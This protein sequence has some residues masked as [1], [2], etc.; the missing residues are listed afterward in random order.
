M[1]NLNEMWTRLAQHQS[2]ADAGGYGDVWRTMCQERTPDVAT[3]AGATLKAAAL[4][5]AWAGASAQKA[6]LR[7]AADAAMMAWAA[8]TGSLVEY[9]ED[10]IWYINKAENI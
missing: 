4:D 10:A 7:S 3:I 9:A 8:T 6:R 1:T 5:A 2:F